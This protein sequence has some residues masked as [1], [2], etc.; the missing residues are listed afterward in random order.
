MATLWF[1]I[2]PS[3][4]NKSQEDDHSVW[5]HFQVGMGSGSIFRDLWYSRILTIYDRFMIYDGLLLCYWSKIK[6]KEYNNFVD[7]IVIV[8]TCY[9]I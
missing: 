5:A 4:F 8:I 3:L 9:V 7:D 1:T 6:I 2:L